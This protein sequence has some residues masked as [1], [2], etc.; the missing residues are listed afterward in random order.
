M[1]SIGKRWKEWFYLLYSR[2]SEKDG[3]KQY[4]QAHLKNVGKFCAEKLEPVGL[5]NFGLVLGLCHDFGK[6]APQWQK[7]LLFGQGNVNH[8]SGGVHFI[9]RLALLPKSSPYHGL[10]LELLELT[11]QGHHGGLR[12][13]LSATG[14][15]NEVEG[16]FYTDEDWNNMEQ[17]FFH[18]IASKEIILDLLAKAEIELKIIVDSMKKQVISSNC[19]SFQGAGNQCVQMQIGLLERL[20]HSVLIDAD[21]LDAADF[22]AKILAT[23]RVHWEDFISKLDAIEF[24]T[25][26]INVYRKLIAEEAKRFSSERRGIYQFSA[27]TGAGKNLSSLGFALQTAKIHQKERL[28][29][30]APFLT[31]IE[32]NA[33]S[34]RKALGLGKDTPFLLE[35][36]SNF[37]EEIEKSEKL[38]HRQ[39]S[40]E[41]W[42]SQIIFTSLVQF[43]NT[44]FRS[45]SGRRL[46]GMMNSVIIIDEIQSIPTHC[47]YFFCSFLHFLRDFCNCVILTSTATPPTLPQHFFQLDYAKSKEI[48]HI[49]ED[50]KLVFQRTFFQVLEGKWDDTQISELIL[51]KQR[52]FQSVLCI[53]NTK[54]T[55]FSLYSL[56]KDKTS[57]PVIY[58]STELCPS[59]R[60][61][62]I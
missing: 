43:L 32:Q 11:I 57:V 41:R 24:Q 39:L 59:H 28:F 26:G 1:Y 37:V 62:K 6:I 42:D 12:D 49:T 23:D 34:V 47:L 20:L 25:A 14:E 5:G 52:S 2:I 36:H 27:P 18:E 51:E 17:W 29:F 8:A 13:A 40:T 22:E 33:D 30:I 10:L 38:S 50:I 3:R 45:D 54:S 15:A 21:R 46:Q 53:S 58:L 60:Q 61:E 31:I 9:R 56:V 55:A 35:H 48:V 7:Y 16:D 44:G 19:P 4:L